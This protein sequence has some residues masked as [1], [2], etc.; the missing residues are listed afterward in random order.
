MAS[1]REM[2]D[3]RALRV[4]ESGS[5]DCDPG[6]TLSRLFAYFGADMLPFSVTISPNE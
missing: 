1:S 4:A 3:I 2:S 6:I 5:F